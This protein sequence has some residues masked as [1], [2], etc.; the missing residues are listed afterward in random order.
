LANDV[1]ADHRGKRELALGL[2]ASNRRPVNVAQVTK[3]SP[4][5]Y[6]GGKTWCVPEV[7]KWLQSIERPKTFIEP[8]AG[9][10]IIGL[11]VAVENLASQIL[12]AERD[13]DVAAVWKLVLKDKDQDFEW[14][15]R[16]ILQFNMSRDAVDRVL[17]EHPTSNRLHA[18]RTILKNRVNRGGI[19]APGASLVKGGENGRGLLSRWYP[20]TLVR[21][22]RLIRAVRHKL[23]FRHEDAFRIIEQHIHERGAAF[24]IDPPYTAGGKKAGTRLYVH[25]QIDHEHLFDLLKR[26]QGRFM[27]TYDDSAEVRC[28]ATARGFQLHTVP[29]KSTHHAVVEELIITRSK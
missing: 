23:R 27:A 28:L 12:L 29:M 13:D 5:R 26:A 7:R 20:Q 8:F 3:L 2:Q 4:F 21:R 17:S 14:L 24:F 18:F 22:L 25:N 10:A 11:T 9:G 1:L 15:C 19:M 16:K 6:P